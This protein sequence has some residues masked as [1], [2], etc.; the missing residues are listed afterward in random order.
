MPDPVEIQAGDIVQVQRLE[1]Y[2]ARVAR[3]GPRDLVITPLDPR[4]GDRRIRVSEVR[5]VFRD[6]GTPATALVRLRPSPRQL[7]LEDLER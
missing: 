1:L 7:R 4:I 5:R 3:A 6:V 2:Y